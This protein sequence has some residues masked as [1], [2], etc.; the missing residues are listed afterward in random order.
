MSEKKKKKKHN[1]NDNNDEFR[2]MLELA[3]EDEISAVAMYSTMANMV[4]SKV[5][6]CIILS[7]AKDEWDHAR[8]WMTMLDM[9]NNEND[10]DND[11]DKDKHKR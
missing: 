5:L 8:N 9:Y 2:E 3:I 6:K 11:K 7:I 1:N 4:K 10:N